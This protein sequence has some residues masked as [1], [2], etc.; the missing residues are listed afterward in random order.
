MKESNKEIKE[1]PFTMKWHKYTDLEP[2]IRLRNEGRELI[3]KE[4]LIT[5][6]RDGENVSIWL[7]EKENVCISSHNQEK[8][9]ENITKRMAETPEFSKICN[10]LQVE[11]IEFHKKIILYGELMK[12]VGATQIE[13]KKK[14]CNWI[15]FDIWDDNEKRY[16]D[17]NYVYQRAYQFKIPIVKCLGVEQ[18]KQ[19][20]DLQIIKDKWLKFCKRH[21]REG[22]VGKNYYDN[23]FFKEKIDLPKLKRVRDIQQIQLPQMPEET[24]LR[25]LQ[26][27][28]DEIND[29]IKWKDR[30]IAMPIIAKHISTEAREHNY[31]TPHNFYSYYLN[32]PL[33]KIKVKL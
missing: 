26:H 29:E 8:A 19:L 28:W 24:I 3:G 2:F 22:F 4:I 25:A 1:E 10:L 31:N 16:L 21:R 32:T 23:V 12:R 7:D 15:I 27:A 18:P 5:E 20:E 13:P 30:A 6:K 17:Y 33:E 9:D 11:C 14:H